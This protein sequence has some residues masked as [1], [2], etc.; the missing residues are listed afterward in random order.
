MSQI[1][2]LVDEVIAAFRARRRSHWHLTTSPLIGDDPA[3]QQWRGLLEA[4]LKVFR[5]SVIDRGVLIDRA[6]R[7]FLD[8]EWA[9]DFAGVA[10]E[11]QEMARDDLR[12]HLVDNGMSAGVARRIAAGYSIGALLHE[13]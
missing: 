9:A 11:L 4:R 1:E 13:P 7:R 5:H 3:L 8:G 2:D 10:D 6:H 12:G